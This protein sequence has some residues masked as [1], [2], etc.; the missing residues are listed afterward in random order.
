MKS[1]SFAEP[2][3]SQCAGGAAPENLRVGVNAQPPGGAGGCVAAFFFARWRCEAYSI[4]DEFSSLSA[5]LASCDPGGV[6]VVR[7]AKSPGPEDGASEV[8][9]V[10]LLVFS[11]PVTLES[12]FPGM[13]SSSRTSSRPR[14]CVSEPV[15]PKDV[16][17]LSGWVAGFD[18]IFPYGECRGDYG[19]AF[20]LLCSHILDPTVL[21]SQR[22]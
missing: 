17:T 1:L 9:R 12:L 15:S 5:S 18:S 20:S 19:R 6:L 16:E 2:R 3:A 11:K 8:S 13:T 10:F 7:S 4:D 22:C 21:A 14:L